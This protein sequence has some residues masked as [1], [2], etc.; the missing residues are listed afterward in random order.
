MTKTRDATIRLCLGLV[1][2]CLAVPTTIAQQSGATKTGVELNVAAAAELDPALAEVARAFEE[3]TGKHVTLKFADSASLYSQIRT[4]AA[5]DVFFPADRNDVRR[6]AASGAAVGSSVTNMLATSWCCAFHPWCASN[7]PLG[8]RWWPSGKGYLPH[9]HCR[10]A[11]H[12]CRQSRSR[13]F[14]SR[15][16][17]RCD[18]T[19]KNSGW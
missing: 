6:L 7:S 15:P 14:E 1:L 19:K 13:G 5:F 17:L 11:A 16:R 18:G 2:C 8:I 4:G 9:C 12:S 3:K 10:C